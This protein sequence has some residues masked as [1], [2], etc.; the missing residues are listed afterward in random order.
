MKTL[1]YIICFRSSHCAMII[2]KFT[3]SE[4]QGTGLGKLACWGATPSALAVH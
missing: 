2:D 3:R 4:K 1:P